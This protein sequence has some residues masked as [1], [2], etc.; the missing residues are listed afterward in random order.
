MSR[1]YLKSNLIHFGRRGGRNGHSKGRSFS[2]FILFY[3]FHFAR[4]DGRSPII[5]ERDQTLGPFENDP[6]KGTILPYIQP[7]TGRL[8]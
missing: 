6:Q 2:I 7:V 3:F 8:G 1:F 5:G 4:I